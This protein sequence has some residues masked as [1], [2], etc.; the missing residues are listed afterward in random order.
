[1]RGRSWYDN[2]SQNGGGYGLGRSHGLMKRMATRSRI[3]AFPVAVTLLLALALGSLPFAHR[4]TAETQQ[5]PAFIAFIQAGGTLADLCDG[6]EDGH[7]VAA[8]DCEACRIIGALQVPSLTAVWIPLKRATE[9]TRRAGTIAWVPQ[10]QT[11][12]RPP[13]RGPPIV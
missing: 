5:D 11:G 2:A 10:I 1:M 8:L 9:P 7:G 13:V 3:S 6:P 12:A 4:A